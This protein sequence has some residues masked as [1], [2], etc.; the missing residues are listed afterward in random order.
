MASGKKHASNTF[1]LTPKIEFCILNLS[2]LRMQRH[3]CQNSYANSRINHLTQ[4]TN[5][6]HSIMKNRNRTAIKKK[7]LPGLWQRSC[8]LAKNHCFSILSTL[9]SADFITLIC[10]GFWTKGTVILL[11]VTLKYKLVTSLNWNDNWEK[12]YFLP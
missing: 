9:K 10:M 4:T 6:I 3:V 11:N 2:C 7:N 12:I 8:I 1:S 5:G